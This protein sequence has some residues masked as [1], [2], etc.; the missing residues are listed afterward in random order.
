M[1]LISLR[2]LIVIIGLILLF[3]TGV[4][5]WQPRDYECWPKSSIKN[6]VGEKVEVFSVGSLRIYVYP[7]TRDCDIDHRYK[8]GEVTPCPNG[9]CT[10]YEARQQT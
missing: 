7:F 5:A 4:V 1:A 9:Q 6:K 8:P 2:L 10:L 3:T